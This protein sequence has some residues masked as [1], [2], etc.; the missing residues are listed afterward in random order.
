MP[1]TPPGW[2]PLPPFHY[3]GFAGVDAFFVISG[4]IIFTVSGRLTWAG[5]NITTAAEFFLRRVFRVYPVYW[6]FF[7]LYGLLIVSGVEHAFDAGWK[8]GGF[9][10]FFLFNRNNTQLPP[11]WTLVYEM[12]FYTVGS[13]SLLFGRRQYRLILAAWIGSEVVLSTLNH[14]VPFGAW[15]QSILLDPLLTE[16]GMGCCVAW[17]VEK[18]ETRF[19]RIAAIAWIPLYVLGGYFAQ[20][21]GAP[22]GVGDYRV[23]TFGLG[24]ALV[25]Y[26]I[27]VAE[28]YGRIAPRWL[29]EIGNASYSIYLGHEIALFATRYASWQLG[30]STAIGGFLT[31]LAALL[32]SIGIGLV[33][34]RLFERPMTVFLHSQIKGALRPRPT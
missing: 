7:L 30:V 3:V 1:G 12:L 4:F 27:C 32:A 28:W 5:S 15:Q 22:W 21:P 31:L 14:F 29:I 20:Q 17:L 10:D 19:W 26:A 2:W 33:S 23:L 16:F 11:A 6:L 8:P 24:S 18:K 25:V 9:Y 13:A 34:Y